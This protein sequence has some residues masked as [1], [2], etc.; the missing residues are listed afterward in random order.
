L[1]GSASAIVDAAGN[2][3]VTIKPRG[4]TTWSV[5]QLS[6]EM[7]SAPSGTV[8]T[9]RTNGHLIDSPFSARRASAGGDPPISLRP[10]DDLTVEWVGATPGQQGLVFYIYDEA[11]YR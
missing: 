8:L 6:I 10:G 3:T 7:P 1:K 11:G 9:L 2:C 4:S 5:S